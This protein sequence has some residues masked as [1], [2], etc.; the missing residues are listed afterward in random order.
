MNDDSLFY[1]LEDN[2]KWTVEENGISFLE[3]N[4]YGHINILHR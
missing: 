2:G 3:E 1:L 4:V